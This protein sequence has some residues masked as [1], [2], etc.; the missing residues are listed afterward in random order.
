M[1]MKPRLFTQLG[2]LAVLVAG[3][4]GTLALTGCGEALSTRN[5]DDVAEKIEAERP[6]PNAEDDFSFPTVAPSLSRGKQVLAEKCPGYPAALKTKA[7]V[8]GQRPIDM[9]IDMAHGKHSCSKEMS[10][11]D[12]WAAVFYVRS[13]GGEYDFTMNVADVKALFG[14]NCAVCHGNK[15]KGN[16]PLYTGHASAHELGMAPVKNDFSPPAANFHDLPRLYNRTNEQLVMFVKEGIYPSAMPSWYGRE[17]KDKGVVF[18]DAVITDLVHYV[19]SLSLDSES[20]NNLGDN[21]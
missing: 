20:Q 5:Y 11:D 4:A 10:R 13:L 21:S 18:N 14:A 17:D 6:Q 19:R 16:G 3:F 9:Y 1:M 7:S 12:R 15:G 2:L 8:D